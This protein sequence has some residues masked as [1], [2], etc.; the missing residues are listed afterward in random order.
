[1]FGGRKQW[2]ILLFVTCV[3]CL[4]FSYTQ[5]FAFSASD[6]NLLTDIDNETNPQVKALVSN[7]CTQILASS[8]FVENQFAYNAK[9]SAFVYL[10]CNNLGSVS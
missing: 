10:I 7:Y 9:Y 8:P 5:I 1:M 3:A 2:K 4:F 6:L